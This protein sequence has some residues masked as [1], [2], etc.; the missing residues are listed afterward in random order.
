[1]QSCANRENPDIGI[2]VIG[3]TLGLDHSLTGLMTPSILD[4]LHSINIFKG[5]VKEII[6]KVINN[7]NYNP[8]LG[9]GTLKIGGD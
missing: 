2:Q 8:K 7:N 5:Q 1:L 6:S 3:H 4:K 9:K